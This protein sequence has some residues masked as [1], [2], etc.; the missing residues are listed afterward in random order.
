ME[1]NVSAW[2]LSRNAASYRVAV[3][4]ELVIAEKTSVSMMT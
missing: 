3:A 2:V 1:T 4:R